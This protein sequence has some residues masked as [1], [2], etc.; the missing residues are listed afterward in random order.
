MLKKYKISNFKAQ[1]T[2]YFTI[3]STKNNNAPPNTPI[4][5]CIFYNQPRFL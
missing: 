2:R 5:S 1:Q 4:Y 3:F